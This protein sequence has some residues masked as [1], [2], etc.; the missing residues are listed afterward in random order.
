LN[1]QAKLEMMR[2]LAER[3]LAGRVRLKVGSGEPMQRQGG[4][5]NA[6]SGE[7]AFLAS[8]DADR[9][10]ALHLRESART[11][12]AYATTPMMGMFSGGDLRTLQSAVAEQVRRLPVLDF[13]QFLFHLRGAQQSHHRD[14]VRACEELAE[15]RLRSTRRGEAALERLTVGTREDAYETFL[16]HLTANF[17]QIL[18]GREEDVVGIHII[19]YFIA[20]TTPPLRDRPTVRPGGSGKG[21]GNRILERIAETIPLSRYGSL[22]RAIAHNQAQTVVLGINQLTTGL[23]RALDAFARSGAVEGDPQSFIADRILPRLPVYEI[24]QTLRQYHDRTLA[25]LGAMERAI[26]AGNSAFLALRE[27]V[28]AMAGYIPLLQQELLRRH[29]IDIADFFEGSGFIPDL[30]PTLRPDLAVLLQRDLFNTDLDRLLVQ[31]QGAVDPDWRAAVSTLLDLPRDIGAWR[32]RAWSLL[33]RPV[34]QRVESFVELAIALSSLSPREGGAD[35]VPVSRELRL[36]TSLANF[37]KVSPADDEMR[38]FLAAAVDYL[39]SASSGM[40][41]VPATIVRAMKDVERIAKIEEQALSTDG[42]EKLRFYLL[43]IARLTGE[44]G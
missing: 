19:S 41:E 29:G 20:R 15:S 36:P 39:R 26:P 44:N 8:P 35:A 1:R 40:I 37:F 13:A 31:V 34:L 42:Q 17:R 21:Q 27:D 25:H 9:R 24:L 14:L 10:F 22:L 2:W 32:A 11:S 43:Q 12:T 30:L 7:R 6:R 23:F 3:G 18:Y 28:D 33:E 4:Y 16:T 38:Q 5:Y